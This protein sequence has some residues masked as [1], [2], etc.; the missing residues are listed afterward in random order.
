MSARLASRAILSFFASATSLTFKRIMH[1]FLISG[2]SALYS[3]PGLDVTGL[4]T[5][6]LYSGVYIPIIDTREYHMRFVVEYKLVGGS[7]GLMLFTA[8]NE[9]NAT[10]YV[11][12]MVCRYG[13]AYVSDPIVLTGGIEELYRVTATLTGIQKF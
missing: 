3:A 8:D 9:I 4:L 6:T 1:H 2:I 7:H 11:A 5:Y 10:G 13:Y 12:D